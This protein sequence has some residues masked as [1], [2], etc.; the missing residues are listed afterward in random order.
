[1]KTNQ[2][3]S[4]VG[5]L[6]SRMSL[7]TLVSRV[8]GLLRD[9]SIAHF[10]T[11]TQT[12]IFF[13]AFRFP[14]FF[15]RVLGEGSFSASVTPVLSQS[16]CQKDG[17]P[18]A[19]QLSSVLFTWLFF[20]TSFLTAAG[21][22]F[23]GDIM[24]LFFGNSPYA[25]IEGKLRQTIQAGRVIFV[26]LFLVSSY[27]YFMSV[28]QALGRFFLPALAPALFNISLIVFAFLP[29]SWWPFPAL[30]LAW[31]ALVGGVLQ[32]ALVMIVIYRLGFWPH[33]SLQVRKLPV[34]SVLNRFIPAALGL[35]G[36]SLIGLIN[37]YFAGW[38][39]EGSHTYIYYGDRLLELPRSL[40]AV[41]LGSALVPALSRLRAEKRDREF[42]E[43]TGYYLD[44]LIF[45]TLP[46]AVVLALLAQPVVELL[47]QRGQFDGVAVAHTASVIQIY[48]LVLI[49]SSGGRA[50]SS[51]FFAA[52][53][54]WHCAFGNG[55]YVLFH[56]LIAWYLTVSYGLPGLIWATAL[57]SL[58]Y[59]CLLLYLLFRYVGAL[60]LG[61]SA[62]RFAKNLPGLIL[63]AL[64]LLCYQPLLLFFQQFL[65]LSWSRPFALLILF[66]IGG[67]VYLKAGL[68]LKQEMAH[69]FIRLF[70]LRF[71]AKQ[72]S[73]ST[74]RF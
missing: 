21:I 41:S 16:L 26:Y 8:F 30:S 15:R 37:V 65:S 71:R 53:K 45:L 35:S 55:I 3:H 25:S 22:V 33:F 57:S 7:G 44:F 38:L 66:S 49:F 70:S 40:I 54:N 62:V 50:L 29:Q 68:L 6:A 43:T 67:G 48:S 72:S 56:G 73:G 31:A 2:S 64:V 14:N 61:L 36:L 32:V 1:M 23:M 27:S 28:A 51:G 5:F 69:E 39:E 10:F 20:I 9:M 46:C 19:R 13:V 58:F 34:R 52:D 24:E 12:D 11:R 42:F 4:P 17:E 63:F 47:F 74:E 18:Q 60:P 59:F